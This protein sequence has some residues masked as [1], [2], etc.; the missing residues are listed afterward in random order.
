MAKGWCVHNSICV[1]M[2]LIR[3][4]IG[5]QLETAY[6]LK[7]AAAQ[8]AEETTLSEGTVINYERARQFMDY[9]CRRYKF[10]KADVDFQSV[11]SKGA[12]EAVMTVGGR[13]IGMG[14]G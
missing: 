10:G 4:F 12:W 13:R 9:Y 5:G 8:S 7:R 11:A 1:S 14:S 3:F 6:Q 2:L